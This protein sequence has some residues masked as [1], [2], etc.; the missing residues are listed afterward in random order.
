MAHTNFVSS[1]RITTYQPIIWTKITKSCFPEFP[2]TFVINTI[3][4]SISK[5]YIMYFV[6]HIL[7]FH[8]SYILYF[9]IFHLFIYCWVP[10]SLTSRDSA[11]TME[12]GGGWHYLVPF[13]TLAVRRDALPWSCFFVIVGFPLYGPPRENGYSSFRVLFF[14]EDPFRH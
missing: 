11:F 1:I 13:T 6:F 5:W 10:H 12:W 2:C 9:Y 7:Y 4:F 14:S 8:T 3:I